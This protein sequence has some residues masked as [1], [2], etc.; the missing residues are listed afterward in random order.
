M[1]SVFLNKSCDYFAGPDS[2]CDLGQYPAYAVNVSS[3]QDIISTVEFAKK[4]NIRLVVK[5]TGH[6]CG[7][8]L[9]H[10]V[11]A[12]IFIVSATWADRQ[13]A[14]PYQYGLTTSRN[15]NGLITTAILGQI[16]LVRQ[17]KLM[18]AFSALNFTNKLMPGVII[19]LGENVQLWALSVDTSKVEDTQSY[20]RT[21]AW[22]LIMFCHLKSSRPRASS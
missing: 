12:L 3:T 16:T 1:D 22:L 6:E 11:G 15:K 19:L 20:P 21:R 13:D 17:S 4:H 14:P 2:Q 10:E 8:L 5:N 9:P 7:L 18:L